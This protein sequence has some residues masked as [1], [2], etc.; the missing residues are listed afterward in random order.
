MKEESQILSEDQL[1]LLDVKNTYSSDGGIPPNDCHFN[2]IYLANF[3]ASQRTWLQQTSDIEVSN[4]VSFSI[5]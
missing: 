4:R 5:V 3:L 1:P 2:F